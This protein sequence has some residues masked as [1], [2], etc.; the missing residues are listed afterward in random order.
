MSWTVSTGGLLYSLVVIPGVYKWI[1]I[2]AQ[3]LDV[4]EDS[5]LS[6]RDFPWY[7]CAATISL[8]SFGCQS[9]QV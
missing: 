8:A 5:I 9:R 6:G 7:V 1:K 2:R 3:R 4:T